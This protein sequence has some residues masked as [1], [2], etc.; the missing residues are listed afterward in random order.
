LVLVGVALLCV[1]DSAV[2]TPG[3]L[4][5]TFGSGGT[6][7]TPIGSG[8]SAAHALAA[9]PDG[10]IL[11]GGETSV[12]SEGEFALARYNPDGSLDTSFGTSGKVTT[13]IGSLYDR[14]HAVALQADG[15][16]VAAGGSE[17][18]P[19]YDFAVARYNPNGSLDPSFGTDGK[20]AT[21]IAVSGGGEAYAIA[22]QTDGK[23]V[24]GGSSGDNKDFVIA[25]YNPDG[26]LDA[27]FGTSGIVTTAT[28]YVRALAL[29]PDG[30]IV[31]AGGCCAYPEF[32]L[33]RYNQD[34]SLDTSFG[35][36]GTVTTSPIGQGVGYALAVQPDGKLDVAGEIDG[37]SS[38]SFALLRFNADGSLDASF[39]SGGWVMTP[40]GSSASGHALALQPDGELV[41]AGYSSV[42]AT[43]EFALTRYTADGSQAGEFIVT[44][45]IGANGSVA[46]A[47]ALEPDG[48]IVAGGYTETGSNNTAGEQFALARYLVT[49]TLT[50]SKSGDGSGSVTSNPSGIDCGGT[51]SAPFAAVPV[52][53]VAAPAAG[54]IF[55]GWVPGA[56]C[57]GTGTCTVETSSDRSVTAA[58]SLAPETLT[59]TRSGKG[60]GEVTSSPAG[61]SCGS[62][63]S[64]AYAYGTTLTLFARP[65]S[66]SVF[67]GWSGACLGTGTCS[68]AVKGGRSVTAA[69]GL[70]PAC[71]VPNLKGKSLKVARHMIRRA[72]C[73]TGAIKRSYSAVRKG[74]VI[75][76][77]PRRRRH[78][79]N[80]AKVSLILSKGRR[81]SP[82]SSNPGDYNPLSLDV[83][84]LELSSFLDLSRW[85]LLTRRSLGRRLPLP[86]LGHVVSGC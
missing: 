57:S 28:G 18:P 52:T 61:I 81:P 30:K 12:G 77:K 48:K 32:A 3:V 1:V 54:S 8:S 17:D 78:L 6:V 46:D 83:G 85:R 72:R 35:A 9:Q 4:D 26:S 66:G 36:G 14:I 43:H 33:A 41:L 58:F 68:M 10:K 38:S 80:G 44:T 31:A 42:G 67:R 56:G 39:G 2:A 40:I 63:C 5:P 16:I 22:V 29:L 7:T 55:T 27:S 51:C 19:N 62:A 13:A 79:R 25:R 20:V 50:I 21:P 23:I 45:P 70:K 84:L 82:T 11:A 74:R 15:K 59:V 34:G 53:L 65:A 49:S 69:F 64:H 73:R 60:S 71:I 37:F 24:V 47:L 75:S 86:Y 76:Q